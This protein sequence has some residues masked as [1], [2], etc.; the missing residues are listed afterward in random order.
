MGFFDGL[1][2][3]SGGV[4]VPSGFAAASHILITGEGAVERASELQQRIADG[5]LTF[6][7]AANEYSQCPSK[8]KAGDLGVFSSLS[9][10]SFTPYEGK[11]DA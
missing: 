10:V 1:F 5:Q 6:A 8:G 4:M 9:S 11:G 7:D 2:S 3:G